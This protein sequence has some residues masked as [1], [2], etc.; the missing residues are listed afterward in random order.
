MKAV[1]EQSLATVPS[2][3]FFYRGLLTISS[4]ERSPRGRSHYLFVHNLN[5]AGIL[6]FEAKQIAKSHS[7]FIFVF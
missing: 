2:T 7:G 3:A 5:L 4:D 1:E 6:Y